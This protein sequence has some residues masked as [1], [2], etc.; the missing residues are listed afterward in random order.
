MSS[1]NPKPASQPGSQPSGSQQQG[2][3]SQR[4]SGQGG[5]PRYD[6]RPESQQDREG[7]G[8]EENEGSAGHSTKTPEQRAKESQNPSKPRYGDRES[9]E[10]RHSD[11]EGGHGG[12]DGGSKKQ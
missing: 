9:G 6:D 1:Q 5:M 4:S 3:S 2:G 8:R 12:S 7:V 10:P 11:V